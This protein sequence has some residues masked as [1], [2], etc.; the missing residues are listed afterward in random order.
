MEKKRI[1]SD[2]LTVPRRL[3]PRQCSYNMKIFK[4]LILFSCLLLSNCISS[5]YLQE[6]PISLKRSI[7]GACKSY[8]TRNDSCSLMIRGT[9]LKNEF[10]IYV[11]SFKYDTLDT[12]KYPDVK[13]LNGIQGLAN[14]NIQYLPKLEN[15][16]L[17]CSYQF[18]DSLNNKY[19]LIFGKKNEI[20]KSSIIVIPF[21]VLADILTSPLQLILFAFMF[22]GKIGFA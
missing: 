16:E 2:R 7:T 13:Y 17:N 20:N 8:V 6:H 9:L 15:N 10:G 19:I 21:T 3:T 11:V 22:F 18:T 1:G 5:I 12:I 14:C 4:V